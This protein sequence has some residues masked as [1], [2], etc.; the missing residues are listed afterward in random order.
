MHL[1]GRNVSRREQLQRLLEALHSNGIA[2]ALG[3]SRAESRWGLG[4][5]I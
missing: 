2:A 1:F 5:M 3:I 4:R